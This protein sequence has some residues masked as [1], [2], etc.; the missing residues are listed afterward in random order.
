MVKSGNEHMPPA[1]FEKRPVKLETIKEGAVYKRIHWTS[2]SP[3]QFNQSDAGRYNSPK[4]EFGVLYIAKNL[5]GCFS[6]TLLREKSSLIDQADINARSVSEI[7]F[8]ASLK[9]IS[10]YG[11]GLARAGATAIVSSGD[12]DI[13]QAWSLALWRRK[14]QPYGILYRAKHDNDEL[15][16]AIFDRAGKKL[17][18]GKTWPLKDDPELPELFERYQVGIG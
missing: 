15:C 11:P 5:A 18:K 17:K 13:S 16:A 7:I 14:E 2:R 4:G 9:L 3:V 8:T 10:F 12:W 6:E 1:D